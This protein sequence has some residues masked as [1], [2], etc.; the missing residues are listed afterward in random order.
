MVLFSLDPLLTFD[1]HSFIPF[2][3]LIP[4]YTASFSLSFALVHS[5]FSNPLS[6]RGFSPNW[7]KSSGV[8]QNK[9]SK[10]CDRAKSVK[11]YTLIHFFFHYCSRAFSTSPLSSL[12]FIQYFFTSPLPYYLCP[13]HFLTNCPGHFSLDIRSQRNGLN[14]IALFRHS[15]SIHL[16][17]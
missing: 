4:S 14:T 6:T 10:E 2:F 17:L 12:H 9:I 13:Y 1:S 8:I 11:Y 7:I 16:P 5:W 15:S 3:I